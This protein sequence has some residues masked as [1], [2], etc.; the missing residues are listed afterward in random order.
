MSCASRMLLAIATT[1]I[2][3]CGSA[4]GERD[5]QTLLRLVIQPSDLPESCDLIW[6]SKPY[7]MSVIDDSR[8]LLEAILSFWF[9]KSP[10]H[11]ES[12]VLAISNVYSD[13]GGGEYESQLTILSLAFHSDEAASDAEKSLTSQF[14]NSPNHN[15]VRKGRIVVVAGRKSALSTECSTAVW[16]ETLRRLESAA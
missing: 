11:P 13:P 7:P 10:V 5:A 15:F 9:P 14:N 3:G 2:V 8:D 12:L 16:N 1:V 4:G 6:K